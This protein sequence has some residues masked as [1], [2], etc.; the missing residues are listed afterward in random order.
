MFFDYS[1]TSSGHGGLFNEPQ[2]VYRNG[3]IFKFIIE[4]KNSDIITI[5][6]YNLFKVRSKR[7][8]YKQEMFICKTIEELNKYL[9]NFY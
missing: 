5:P 9:S 6:Y 4:L 7:R 8:V 2:Y 1:R 3:K